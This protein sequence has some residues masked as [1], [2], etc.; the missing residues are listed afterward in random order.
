M[1][2]HVSD[3][4]KIL[5]IKVHNTNEPGKNVGVLVCGAKPQYLKVAMIKCIRYQI[6][7][8]CQRAKL[9]V[10]SLLPMNKLNSFKQ[11]FL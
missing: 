3:L 6:E 11:R 2:F 7:F 4:I 1:N 9:I 5:I 8:I 10:F